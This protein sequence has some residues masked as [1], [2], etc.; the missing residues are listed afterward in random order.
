MCAFDVAVDHILLLL[1][2]MQIQSIVW[3]TLHSIPHTVCNFSTSVTFV[4]CDLCCCFAVCYSASNSL[5][6]VQYLRTKPIISACM[7]INIVAS[8]HW[9][10]YNCQHQIPFTPVLQLQRSEK[11][12]DGLHELTIVIIPVR[13]GYKRCIFMLCLLSFGS[14]KFDIAAAFICYECQITAW[15]CLLW[16]SDL[17]VQNCTV[18]VRS[19]PTNEVCDLNLLVVRSSPETWYCL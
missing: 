16:V 13:F 2:T 15:S 8:N 19:P 14:T 3:Q 11:R 9:L 12:S 4:L 17:F 18:W 7:Y 6:S 10:C 5:M 1:C